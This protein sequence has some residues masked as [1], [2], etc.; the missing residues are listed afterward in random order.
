VSSWLAGAATALWLGLVTAISPCP[1][2]TNIA[3]ISYLGRQTGGARAALLRSASYV[4]GRSL[5]YAVVAALIVAGL[6]AIPGTSHFLER[7]MNRLLGPVLVLVGAVLLDLLPMPLTT[8][9]GSD[10]LRAKLA[11]SGYAG[12][13]AL[14]GLF[15]LSFCPVSGALYF[16]SLIPLALQHSSPFGMPVMFGVGTGAPVLV[17]GTLIAV[18]SEKLGTVLK[19]VEKVQRWVKLVTGLV[20]VGVGIYLT[21]RFVF[22]A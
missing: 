22:L 10:R 7:F 16:G 11:A 8:T 14:G 9:A 3:A 13:L 20:F 6:L 4:A 18:G 17:I 1:L 15:A 21:V 19:K 12:S 5:V 2:A